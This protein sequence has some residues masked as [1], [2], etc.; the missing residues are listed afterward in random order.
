MRKFFVSY[1]WYH[2]GSQGYGSMFVELSSPERPR[3]PLNR[4]A[5]EAM[6][7]WCEADFMKMRPDVEE[8]PRIIILFFHELEA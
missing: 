8:V 4:G 3:V 7:R 6:L 5:I 2:G 1:V